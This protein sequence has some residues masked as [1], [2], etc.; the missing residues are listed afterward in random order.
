MRLK[1]V[2]GVAREIAETGQTVDVDEVFEV[3]DDDLGKRLLDQPAN[4]AAYGV[5]TQSSVDAVLAQVAGDK[6]KAAKA[7]A[8]EESADKPRKTLVD[9]LTKIIDSEDS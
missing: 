5:D 8:E 4:W 1:N 9:A 3:A 7:L 6:T 2:S